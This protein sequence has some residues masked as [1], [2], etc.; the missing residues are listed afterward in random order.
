MRW[1]R[2]ELA[3]HPLGM[4]YVLL[5][6]TCREC[7]RHT[8]VPVAWL[9]S[10]RPRS[11]LSCA[12]RTRLVCCTGLAGL[13]GGGVPN[14][15]A[16]AA[17]GGDAGRAGGYGGGPTHALPAQH[18]HPGLRPGVAPP[19][20]GLRRARRH[21]ARARAHDG[22]HATGACQRRLLPRCVPRLVPPPPSLTCSSY[23]ADGH[24]VSDKRS[25]VSAFGGAGEECSSGPSKHVYM[26]AQ[27]QRSP[28]RNLLQ[29]NC[30]VGLR[31]LSVPQERL[32]KSTNMRRVD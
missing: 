1:F 10:V 19:A 28:L 12:V 2:Y 3:R 27:K 4:H 13:S 30:G 24:A 9:G 7:M 14:R 23:A 26:Q 17:H 31:H 18:L 15:Q 8:C 32:L 20:R 6:G 21:G 16:H 25:A 29:R 5:A 22:R 11:T